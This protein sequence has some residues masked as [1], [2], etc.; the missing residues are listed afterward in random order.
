MGRRLV[1]DLVVG[2]LEVG[3]VVVENCV[4][5]WVALEVVG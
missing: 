2:L 4:L 5:G 1:V 3:T